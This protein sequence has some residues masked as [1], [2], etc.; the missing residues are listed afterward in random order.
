MVSSVAGGLSVGVVLL[1][2]H[3]IDNR[4]PGFM[5][6]VQRFIPNASAD[7]VADTFVWIAY[8]GIAVILSACIQRSRLDPRSRW[9]FFTFFALIATCELSRL[10]CGGL[11]LSAPYW[12]LRDLR[13]LAV[14]TSIITAM[15]ITWVSTAHR[16]GRTATAEYY[17]NST[18]LDAVTQLPPLRV[19][20]SHIKRDLRT[21]PD[22][23]FAVIVLEIDQ[24]K[25][26]NQTL[27]HHA[28][29][30][31]MAQAAQRISNAMNRGDVI[32]RTGADQFAIYLQRPL[33]EQ[34]MEEV[35]WRLQRSISGIMRVEGGHELA[36][37]ACIGVTLYPTG[38]HDAVSAAQRRDRHVPRT[39]QGRHGVLQ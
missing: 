2:P 32:A 10:V 16:V 31:L 25:R 20:H 26:V 3:L 7:L 38:G 39:Q 11:F 29:N 19:I 17:A 12:L 33:I 34:R 18:L 4:F 8:V 30:Q 6:F 5:H 13:L 23:R 9:M 15:A 21:H 28:G 37:S 27:G 22:R 14:F 1:W 35:A 36:V 24:F